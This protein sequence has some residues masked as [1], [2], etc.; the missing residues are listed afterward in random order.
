[1]HVG[2]LTVPFAQDPFESVL[3]FAETASI[4][5]LE[6]IAHPGSRHIDATKLT[7]AK[8]KQVQAPAR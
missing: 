5:S 8:A 6:V 3:D 7:P 1:M 4:Q 2:M